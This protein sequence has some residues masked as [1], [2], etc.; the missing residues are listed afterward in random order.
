MLQ[1]FSVIILVPVYFL[2]RITAVGT[3]LVRN[4]IGVAIGYQLITIWK[5]KMVI[6]I[7]N[8]TGLMPLHSSL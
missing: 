1:V 8:G 7:L 5:Q 6:R 4:L 3:G 2:C